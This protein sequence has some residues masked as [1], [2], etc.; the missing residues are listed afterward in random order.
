MATIASAPIGYRPDLLIKGRDDEVIALVEVKNPRPFSRDTALDLYRDIADRTSVDAPYFLVLS[1]TLGFLWQSN[2]L[3]L[4]Q[5]APAAEFSMQSVMARYAPNLASGERL[6]GRELDYIVFR[7]LSTLTAG[8]TDGR[9]EQ[10]VSLAKTG[11]LTAIHGRSIVFE[12]GMA[13]IGGIGGAS[14][15]P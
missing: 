8:P 13:A 6:R 2:A 12:A 1:Q 15:L 14:P 9:T 11:F 7:W 5:L 4:Q 3:H 10:E